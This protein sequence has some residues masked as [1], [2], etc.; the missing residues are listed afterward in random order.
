MTITTHQSIF[1]AG[2]LCIIGILPL[3]D[4]PN[5]QLIVLGVCARDFPRQWVGCLEPASS[6]LA[7]FGFERL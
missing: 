4:L 5:F 6:L 7:F 1:P 2:S 3:Y